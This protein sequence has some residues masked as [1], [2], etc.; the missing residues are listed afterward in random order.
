MT[1]GVSVP[2]DE[3]WVVWF[4]KHRFEHGG[5]ILKRST[6]PPMASSRGGRYGQESERKG[7]VE[8]A[9][10]PAGLYD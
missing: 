7:G 3:R 1:F 9:S 4:G 5:P 8:V 6:D 10:N 2:T